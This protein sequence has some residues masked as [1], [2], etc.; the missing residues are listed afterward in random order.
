MFANR[1][2]FVKKLLL[3][4]VLM[5]VGGAE[6]WGQTTDYSGVYYIRSTGK[7]ANNTALYYLCPTEGWYFY[8]ATNNYSE[9][10]NGQPFLTTY[11]IKT[12][13]Y[14][15]SKAVWIIEKHSSEENCYYI[16]QRS[17]GRY[18]VSNGQI[19]GSS[20]ANRVRIHLETVADAAAL[21]ALGNMALFEI[22]DHDEHLDIMPHAAAGRNG[23]NKY[24][25]V[26][27]GN[28]YQLDAQ[29]SKT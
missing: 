15:T 26:N 21:T 17:T 11:Q 14:D 24:L 29:N 2:S 12:N 9:S 5:T 13:N 27:N 1:Y 23:D 6:A 25:V 20:N 22:T 28:Y 8:E 16:K 4:M 10:D 18:I 19:T 3:L 7:N